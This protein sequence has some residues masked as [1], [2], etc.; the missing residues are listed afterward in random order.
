MLPTDFQNL[1]MQHGSGRLADMKYNVQRDYLLN[2]AEQKSQMKSPTPTYRSETKSPAQVLPDERQIMSPTERMKQITI[3][4]DSDS[5]IS[6]SFQLSERE[7]SDLR[8]SD[9]IY[10]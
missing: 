2:L 5:S 7:R 1:V 4:S 9:F 6:Q 3:D 8:K 10:S